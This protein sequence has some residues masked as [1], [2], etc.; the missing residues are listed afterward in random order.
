MDENR[1]IPVTF[2]QQAGPGDAVLLEEGFPLPSAAYVVRF[3]VTQP[4][5]LTG[6]S[7]CTARP[8]AAAVLG[9]AFRDRATGAAPFFTRLLVLAS[10]AGQKNVKA[11]LAEDPICRARFRLALGD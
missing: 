1:R 9:T 8:P 2:E 3:A 5:H 10:P 6:C 11:A 4:G 7:C